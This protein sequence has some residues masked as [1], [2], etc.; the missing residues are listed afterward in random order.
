MSDAIHDLSLLEVS[1]RIRHREVTSEAVTEA[2]LERIA[3]LEPLLHAFV[4]VLPDTAV[5]E[6]READREIDAGRWRGLLHG[7]P[8]GIKDLL[9]VRDV[10]TT[11]GMAL[12]RGLR[13]PADAEAVSRLREAG[14]V[15]LGKLHMSEGGTAEHHPH[16]PRPTNPWSAAHHPGFSSSG[17][18]IATAAGL[19][20][21]AI[22]TDTAGSICVPS[23]ANGVC[24]IKPT[25]GRVSRRGVVPVAASLDT[26]GAIARSVTDAAAILQVLAGYDPQDPTSLAAAVPDYCTDISRGVRGLVLGVDRRLASD[27]LTPEVTAGIERAVE[28]FQRLGVEVREVRLPDLDAISEAIRPLLVME[29]AAAHAAHFPQHAE[30]YGAGLRSM[31]EKA[32]YGPLQLVHAYQS[33]DRCSGQ[34]RAALSAAD[35][36]IL[37]AL[38]AVIPTWDEFEALNRHRASLGRRL[39]RYT[40]PFNVAGLPTLTLPCAWSEAGLPLGMQLAA[41]AL[42]ESILCRAGAAFQQVTGF[43]QRR[44]ALDIG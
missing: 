23:A 22:G 30:Q 9:H 26:V 43:H 6:A 39:F 37:P 31:L 35:F 41:P 42:G 40:T 1:Q 15:L 20:F 29:I 25:W 19:C 16:F 14:A 3:R 11:A 44:P 33:R 5:A 18:A 10:P 36:V 24:G 28:V 32:R 13:A 34:L 12:L 2:L 7:V 8:L 38:S 17:S 21:G 4:Q 27:D